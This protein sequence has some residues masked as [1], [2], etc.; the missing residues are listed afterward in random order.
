LLWRRELAEAALEQWAA[1]VVSYSW[2]WLAPWPLIAVRLAAGEVADA[3]DASR[4]MLAP[5]QER[6]PD[7]LEVLVRS[8]GDGWDAHDPEL[9]G[10]SLGD[11]LALAEEL[12]YISAE[13][14]PSIAAMALG[15]R[16]SKSMIRAS[17]GV[18]RIRVVFAPFWRS[19]STQARPCSGPK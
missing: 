19:W 6:L 13:P 16:V 9:A 4:Q 18:T 2:Y 1:T 11:A 14:A 8:A 5:P 7:E 17:V 12:C 15:K 10:H 3:I